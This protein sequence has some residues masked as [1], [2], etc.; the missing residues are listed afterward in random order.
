VIYTNWNAAKELLEE[1]F[2]GNTER[3]LITEL[4]MHITKD[5]GESLL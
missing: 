4:L 3:A 1:R 2:T 5:Y